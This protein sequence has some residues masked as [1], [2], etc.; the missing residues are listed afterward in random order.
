MFGDQPFFLDVLPLPTAAA[1]A[2]SASA[3]ASEV[4]LSSAW[5]LFLEVDERE[6]YSEAGF[7]SSN[8]SQMDLVSQR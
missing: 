6:Q 1:V 3:S 2:A 4:D 8:Y 7:Y 5:L